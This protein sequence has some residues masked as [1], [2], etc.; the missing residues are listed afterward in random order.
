[1]TSGFMPRDCD[2]VGVG[3]GTLTTDFN[4]FYS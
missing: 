2:I 1:M 4:L 3:D